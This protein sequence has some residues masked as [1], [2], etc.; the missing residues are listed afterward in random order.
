[1]KHLAVGMEGKGSAV[2]VD[3]GRTSNV[4][5]TRDALELEKLWC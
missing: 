1:M 4:C 2:R 5:L 3:R